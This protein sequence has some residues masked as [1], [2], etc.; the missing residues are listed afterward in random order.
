MPH[1]LTLCGW[2]LS[3]ALALPE[4]AGWTG[5]D[6]PADMV[7][8]MGAVPEALADE[9]FVGRFERIA[10][11]GTIRIAVPG[12]A[13]F[14]VQGG[15]RV[16]VAPDLPEDA[17]ELGH[18]LL[19]GVIGDLLHQRGVLPL[20]A[21]CV[22]VNGVAVA[23]A[24]PS[25]AGKSTLAAALA[26]AGHQLLGDDITVVELAADGTPWVRPSF[27]RQKLWGD[28]LTALGLPPGRSLRFASQREKAGQREKFEHHAGALFAAAPFPL[29]VL[30]HLRG[31][32]DGLPL[33]SRLQ[34]LVALRETQANLYRP[35]TPHRLG[36]E[37]RA[38]AICG[39]LAVLPQFALHHVHDFG[40]LSDLV[41][42]LP[43]L[44]GLESHLD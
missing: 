43:G 37:A 4:L 18:Y 20:H 5:D 34:R 24:G 26:V 44:L 42:S 21:S 11:D 16:V 33:V 28:S 23:F 1:D 7:V 31:D 13:A 15:R 14:L 19:G 36:T 39:R 40:R 30:C 35:T 17:P 32:G 38:F 25:G 8:E 12:I 6:R 10:R 2:R 29:G 3:S 22:A 27:P 41:A 9:I